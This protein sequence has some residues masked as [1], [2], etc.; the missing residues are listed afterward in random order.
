MGYAARIRAELRQWIPAGGGLRDD[1]WAY[2]HRVLTV[3]LA[4]GVAG[5]TGFGALRD[6]LGSVLIAVLIILPCVVAAVTLRPRRLPS[7]LV[8]LGLAAACGSFVTLSGGLTEA[9][10]TFFI[11]IAALALY[12]DWAPFGAFLVA[13]VVHHALFGTL[14]SDL[15]YAHHSAAVHPWIWALLHGLAVLLAA[16]FQLFGWRLSEAEERRADAD[17]AESRAQLDVAF[18]QTPVPMAMWTPDGRIVRM[19]AAYQTWL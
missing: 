12:R 2:R 6:Q 9:H 13:T 16:A 7:V 10:F 17:L 15:T 1:D 8:A 11:A 5:L 18:D 14:W 4:A 19:N 3:L